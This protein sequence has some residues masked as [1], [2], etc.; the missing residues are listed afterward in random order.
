M[1]VLKRNLPG[2]GLMMPARAG[3]LSAGCAGF[4]LSFAPPSATSL[5][6]ACS[7]SSCCHLIHPEGYGEMRCAK[8]MGKVNMLQ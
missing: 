1:A 3:A 4:S 8:S 2:T 5:S 6:P 7:A